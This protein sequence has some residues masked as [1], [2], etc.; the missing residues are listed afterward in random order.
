MEKKSNWRL[1]VKFK[2]IKDES[3]Y[4]IASEHLDELMDK[5][6]LSHDEREEMELI[7][8]LIEEYEEM[9]YPIELPSPI[10]AIFSAWADHRKL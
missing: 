2:I 8:H 9:A 1:N 6:E 3:D 5:D 4:D 7:A 10:A